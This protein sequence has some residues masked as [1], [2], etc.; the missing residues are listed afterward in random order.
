V[1]KKGIDKKLIG[2]III[3]TEEVVYDF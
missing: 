2:S 3:E 1:G